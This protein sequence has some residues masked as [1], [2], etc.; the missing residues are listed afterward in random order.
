MP[1]V[2]ILCRAGLM[3]LNKGQA[4]DR[5]NIF[6]FSSQYCS[7][8]QG[9]WPSSAK[10]IRVGGKGD[11]SHVNGLVK[12]C[13][14]VNHIKLSYESAVI[15]HPVATWKHKPKSGQSR[16]R[17]NMSY[18]LEGFSN[19]RLLQYKDRWIPNG[20]WR[21]KSLFHIIVGWVWVQYGE[22]LYSS[23]KGKIM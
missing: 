23:R 4:I 5:V 3:A 13:F 2:H 19:L 16:E 22:L 8:I 21:Q 11:I 18:I 15:C 6:S 10:G 9:H 12:Q 1:S 20:L 17:H 14:S 7:Q